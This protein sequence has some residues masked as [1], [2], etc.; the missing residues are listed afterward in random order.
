MSSDAAANR[1]VVQAPDEILRILEGVRS[2]GEPLTA[3]VDSGRDR[4]TSKLEGLLVCLFL[5][6]FLQLLS[7]ALSVLQGQR[8]LF[9]RFL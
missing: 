1:V 3:F 9:F 5:V 7:G 4:F 2:A 6:V 8:F